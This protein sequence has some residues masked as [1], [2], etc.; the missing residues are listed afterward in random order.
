MGGKN[1]KNPFSKNP[2]GGS[3]KKDHREEEGHELALGAYSGGLVDSAFGFSEEEA[4]EV[5]L[6]DQRAEKDFE[7]VR[8]TRVTEL[9]KQDALA[10]SEYRQYS[11]IQL[12]AN[13]GW[14]Q[15]LPKAP[16]AQS[17]A[18]VIVAT[19]APVGVDVGQPE[20]PSSASFFV[21]RSATVA[22]GPVPPA[23][24]TASVGLNETPAAQ[25]DL[26]TDLLHDNLSCSA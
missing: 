25:Y 9:R 18:P 5:S 17:A 19:S 3:R 14:D 6:E 16:E 21:P 12:T 23:L 20:Q 22:S 26:M 4:D 10:F 24:P 11:R 13:R 2:Q 8:V 1:P 7:G 15:Y